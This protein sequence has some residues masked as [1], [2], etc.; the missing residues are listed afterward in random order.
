MLMVPKDDRVTVWQS[1]KVRDRRIHVKIHRIQ[2]LISSLKTFGR[3]IV[4]I[5]TQVNK[6]ASKSIYYN[7]T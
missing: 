3:K 2:I 1:G 5:I 6:T 7:L 4:V